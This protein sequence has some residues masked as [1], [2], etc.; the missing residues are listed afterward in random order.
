MTGAETA[1]VI[2]EPAAHE[3]SGNFSRRF[4]AYREA[5][6]IC[7]VSTDRGGM[8]DGDLVSEFEDL[9]KAYHYAQR[10]VHLYTAAVAGT[11][12]TATQKAKCLASHKLAFEIVFGL[13]DRGYEGLGY[14]GKLLKYV[15][16]PKNIPWG[17]ADFRTAYG[18]SATFPWCANPWHALAAAEKM[19][20]GIRRVK[21]KTAEDVK[22]RLFLP[23]EV[24]HAG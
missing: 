12:P 9:E 2:E 4:A 1:E 14:N 7:E 18:V 6:R 17:E 20:R 16:L 8:T 13:V 19:T 10:Y 11:S 21:A 24:R 22:L 5:L 15:A 23:L 3:L